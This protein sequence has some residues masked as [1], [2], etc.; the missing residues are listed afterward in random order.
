MQIFKKATT[1][2]QTAQGKLCRHQ[3]R[4]A[5]AS[6]PLLAAR[7]QGRDT[8][9]MG[10]TERLTEGYRGS[11]KIKAGKGNKGLVIDFSAAK[12]IQFGKRS[13]RRLKTCRGISQSW[14][15]G[16]GKECGEQP[17]SGPGVAA[18]C[19]DC[20]AQ[21]EGTAHP[22]GHA[23]PAG[24]AP[25]PQG[26]RS[27]GRAIRKQGCPSGGARMAPH[28]GP[29]PWPWGMSSP[30]GPSPTAQP[31]GHGHLPMKPRQDHYSSSQCHAGNRGCQGWTTPVPPTA[32]LGLG[33]LHCVNG[34][35]THPKM[36]TPLRDSCRCL[37]R[38]GPWGC[39]APIT[40]WK[41]S[42]LFRVCCI[43][44][45]GRAMSQCLHIFT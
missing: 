26:R 25:C 6:G 19:H 12:P 2:P 18:R 31:P 21:Q 5:L 29:T 36:H 13:P 34:Q 3:G 7:W 27:L 24:S 22:Q 11:N 33:H 16:A 4:E 14:G 35:S 20:P 32:L 44:P 43:T 42:C 39:R 1:V 40:P 41:S 28:S 17:C 8:D 30:K 9:R 37:P 45:A 38:T 15:K 23:A 10:M